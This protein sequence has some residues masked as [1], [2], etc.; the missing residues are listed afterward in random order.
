MPM[1][2]PEWNVRQLLAWK[3]RMDHGEE[4]WDEPD[5]AFFR[6]PVEWWYWCRRCSEMTRVSIARVEGGVA[7]TTSNYRD[8]LLGQLAVAD[9]T[10]PWRNKIKRTIISK[11]GIL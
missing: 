3:P 10:K 4:N 9:P 11:D 6:R 2:M 5:D 8:F 1:V 7:A